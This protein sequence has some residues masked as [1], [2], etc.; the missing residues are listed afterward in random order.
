MADVMRVLLVTQHYWP[1]TVGTA[2]RMQLLG[3]YLSAR[4]HQVEVLCAWPNHPSM[5]QHFDQSHE[6][7]HE[8]V[9]I[10]RVPVHRTTLTYTRTTTHTYAQPFASVESPGA[11]LPG[12]ARLH[13]WA[14]YGSWLVR[15]ALEAFLHR[16]RWDVIVAVSPLPTGMVGAV[17]ALRHRIPLVFDLQDI[18]PEAAV[19]AGMLHDRR[20]IDVLER[21]ERRVYH[22]SRALVVLSPGFA[23]HL[24]A[25]GTPRDRIH[26]I[27]NSVDVAPHLEED[28]VRL[29]R[30]WG[31]T[32]EDTLLIYAGNMGIMQDLDV[33]L[34]AAHSLRSV[35]RI[36][37]LLVGEGVDRERLQQRAEALGLTQVR[38]MEPRPSSEIPAL[39]A[40]ADV[41]FLS[42][43]P[44]AYMAGTIPSKLYEYLAAGRPILN[45]VGGD[46]AATVDAAGAGI[47]L[48][49]GDAPA[50][51]VALFGLHADPGLRRK[52]GAAGRRF[53]IQEASI[54][55]VGARYEALLHQVADRP[56]LTV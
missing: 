7:L 39:L 26:V 51:R 22:H 41:C 8:G 43:R 17:L 46:A 15:G 4:G 16:T 50:L 14:T 44:G 20:L 31:L 24:E 32:P 2:R 28:G 40:A 54:D 52:L 55:V 37:F 35:K 5:S 45:L 23:T 36:R 18:W 9:R 47:N 48:R 27:P 53:V 12:T 33:L 38:F 10:H 34:E 11:L 19:Q 30:I 25:R 6:Q 3:E 29:R 56:P 42:L 13:R 49:P 1:E 21:A